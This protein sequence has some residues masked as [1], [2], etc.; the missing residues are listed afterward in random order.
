MERTG[1]GER[2]EEAGGCVCACARIWVCAAPWLLR[3]LQGI[4]KEFVRNCAVTKGMGRYIDF[5]MN[6]LVAAFS[7]GVCY[8]RLIRQH[9]LK[10]KFRSLIQVWTLDSSQY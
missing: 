10:Y 3:N 5:F 6:L 7:A 8:L 1:R 9:L 2:R 4:S